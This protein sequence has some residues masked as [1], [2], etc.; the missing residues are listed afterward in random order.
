MWQFPVVT[1]FAAATLCSGL[2]ISS[3]GS[4]VEGQ[5]FDIRI[6][7]DNE[8]AIARLLKKGMSKSLEVWGG[9]CLGKEFSSE[10]FIQVAS[11]NFPHRGTVCVVSLDHKVVEL[12][13]DF[14]P[15]MP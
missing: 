9:N 5:E 2:P 11:S 7:M 8:E 12:R 15:F 13:W 4:I 10:Y 14:N 1:T 3:F 6:G